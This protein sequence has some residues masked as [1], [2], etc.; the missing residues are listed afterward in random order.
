VDEGH[1]VAGVEVG[2]RGSTS[3]RGREA[4]WPKRPGWS[5]TV[6]APKS[7]A[8][9]DSARAAWSSPKRVPG[10]ERG[11]IAVATPRWPISAR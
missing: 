1:R 6:A 2:P 4:K 10:E 5:R 11:S 9:R 8:C 3:G 7:L